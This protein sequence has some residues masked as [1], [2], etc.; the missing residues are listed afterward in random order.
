MFKYEYWKNPAFSIGTNM[1][2]EEYMLE[3][4]AK[5][6]VATIRFWNVSKDSVVLGYGEDM[7]TN[8]KK[9]DSSF[10]LARRITGGSHIQFDK[11]CLAYTFT[12]VRDGSFNHFEDMRK[13]YSD[14]IVE[15]LN[16]LGVNEVE[17]DNRASTI[18]VD[19]KVIASHAI[20]WGVDSALMHGLILI[21][22][23][24]V[25]KIYERVLL[26]IREIGKHTY[27][28]YDALKSAPVALEVIRNVSPY[29][30]KEHKVEYIKKLITD[31]IL[32]KVTAGKYKERQVNDEIIKEA[33][34]II[35]RTHKGTPW[36]RDREPPYT[37][38]YVEAIPGEEL[39]GNLRRNLG[40]CLYIQVPDNKFAKMTEPIEEQSKK[41]SL[42]I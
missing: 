38:N 24:D 14:M 11:N 39:N 7:H 42:L 1:A 33:M 34:S 6:K 2:L 41:R 4:S 30:D 32:E 27:S 13:Y 3:R 28:E 15:A 20:F 10:D 22:H 21:D 31:K 36:I 16:E 23:L 17:A 40:Y 26:K 8:I 29:I 12:A 5:E 35:E 25:D 9:R 18:E 37:N 19:G